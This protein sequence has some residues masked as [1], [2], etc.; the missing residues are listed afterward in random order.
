MPRMSRVTDFVQGRLEE[1]PEDG[2]PP[3][4]VQLS[5]RISETY[6]DA[7]DAMA[8]RLHMTRTGLAAELLVAA[9]EDS[10]HLVGVEVFRDTQTGEEIVGL[11]ADPRENE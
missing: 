11:F 4:L 9:I 3:R 2:P 5:P 8:E 1:P 10:G 6:A 7:L